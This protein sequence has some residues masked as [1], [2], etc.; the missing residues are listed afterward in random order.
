MLRT[1]VGFLVAPVVGV[2]LAT[3]IVFG[4]E[5]YAV[6]W[7]YLLVGS[8]IAYASALLFG[9]PSY[10]FMRRV[11]RGE[12]W[13][14]ALA[15]GVCGLPYWLISEYPYTTAYFQNQGLTNLILYVAAGAIAGLVFWLITCGSAPSNSTIERDARKSGARPSS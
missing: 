10:L 5:I 7:I 11:K 12:W 8:A 4:R 9:L 15:G 2:A 6:W 13:Q 1:I 14:I 3:L